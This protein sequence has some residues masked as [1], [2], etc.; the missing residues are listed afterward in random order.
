MKTTEKAFSLSALIL[1]A[2][3]VSAQILSDIGSLKISAIS[4]FSFD[5]GTLIYPI[6]FT[7]RDLI[8]K[9]L[10]KKAARTLIILCAGINLL[11]AAFFAIATILPP[12]PLWGLQNEFSAIL[13]PV[14]RIVLASILAEV[15]SELIDTE[16][17]HWWMTKIT[18]KMQWSRVLISN[19][20]SIPIDS[21]I[22]AGIAFS[23]TLPSSVI[24]SIIF[25]NI[26]FKGFITLIS[27]PLI[28]A[29]RE[30]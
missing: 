28:Y 29:V 19:I 30:N 4:G 7:I 18:S 23:G 11:M 1:I 26:A 2:S 24:W 27:I 8:H 15:T 16:I 12:D 25:V 22:F 21:V 20:I 13:G 17:Y 14:W 10:G 3:Y 5:A 9:S 6:T